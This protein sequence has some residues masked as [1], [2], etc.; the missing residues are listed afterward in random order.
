MAKFTDRTGHV[1]L[2]DL[3]VATLNRI[4]A[5]LEVDLYAALDEDFA[6]L[7]ALLEDLPK[8]VDVLYLACERAAKE[9]NVSDEDFGRSLAGDALEDA[10]QAL[11]DAV[12]DFFPHRKARDALQR[13]VRIS[14]QQQSETLDHVLGRLDAIWNASAGNWPASSASIPARTSSAS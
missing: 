14:R 13:A 6:G 1:W 4:R 12:I 5:K 9:S 2:V 3:D 11:V 8:L 7:R 10:G